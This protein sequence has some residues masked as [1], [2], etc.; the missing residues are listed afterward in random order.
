MVS[1]ESLCPQFVSVLISGHDEALTSSG[2]VIMNVLERE[3]GCV[4]LGNVGITL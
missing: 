1:V 4:G 2:S 3:A